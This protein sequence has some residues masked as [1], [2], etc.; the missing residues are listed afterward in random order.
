MIFCC[1]S[2]S[3]KYVR[4]AQLYFFCIVLDPDGNIKIFSGGGIKWNIYKFHTMGLPIPKI[5]SL[6]LTLFNTK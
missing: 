5:Y 6:G 2:Y 1:I 3:N 4:T